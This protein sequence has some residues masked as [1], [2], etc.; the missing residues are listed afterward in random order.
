MTST[1]RHTCPGTPMQQPASS[2]RVIMRNRDSALP[3]QPGDPREAHFQ[4]AGNTRVRLAPQGNQAGL[5]SYL[6]QEVKRRPKD[7]RVHMQRINLATDTARELMLYGA[8]VDLF[9]V[10]GDAGS[11]LKQRCLTQADKVLDTSTQQFLAEH[12][13]AGLSANDPAIAHIR[14]AVLSLG[15]T[16]TPR[17]ISKQAQSTS[18]YQNAY[19]EAAACI[20]YGQLEQAQQIL[21][22]AT[23]RGDDDPRIH[24]QLLE[25]YQH[26]HNHDALQTMRQWLLDNTRSLPDGW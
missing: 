17:I 8:L 13:A 6:S 2:S 18:R 26:T 11:A 22:T 12:A 19:D 16:G 14:H 4:A 3:R 25:I 21:E 23:R 15:F 7:L 9:I 20:E 10:L 24:R 5:F 1:S